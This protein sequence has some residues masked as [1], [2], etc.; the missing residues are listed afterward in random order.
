MNTT[1]NNIFGSAMLALSCLSGCA[2]LPEQGPSTSRVLDGAMPSQSNT[3]TAPYVMIDLTPATAAAVTDAFA[4]AGGEAPV[5]DLPPAKPV[6]LIGPGDILKVTLWQPDPTG[7]ALIGPGGG[8]EFSARVAPDGTVTVP[9]VG[10]IK[11]SRK[12]PAQVEVAI[13]SALASQTA[14]AQASVIVDQDV[15]NA[16]ILE[17]AVSKTG[18]LPLEP[19][20]RSLMDVLA[21]AGGPRAAER[22][23]IVRITREEQTWT[24]NLDQ[25]VANPALDVE[26]SPGDRILVTPHPKYFYAFGAVGH[27]GEQPFDADDVSMART[28]A[29][30]SGLDDQRANARGV[31]VFRHQDAALTAH[32]AVGAIRPD[33]DPT[34]VVYRFDMR[35]PNSF[36]ASESFRVLPEDI[37]YVSDAPIMDTQK[38]LSVING[39]STFAQSPRNLGAP[40]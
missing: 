20:E 11:V 5:G 38:V 39:V 31:F 4:R 9:Y 17:G 25:I 30:I 34:R 29:R 32:V 36:F 7:A 15:T 23:S 6:G 28:L 10:R 16:V 19:G 21:V 35:D 1:R 8:A 40:Y 22:D 37:V 24:V 33:Q 3:G 18:I 26:L 2:S 27:P 14:G 13:R 12:T